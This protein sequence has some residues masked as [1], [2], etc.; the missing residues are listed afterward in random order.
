MQNRNKRAQVHVN[1][2]GVFCLCRLHFC[3]C[4]EVVGTDKRGGKEELFFGHL[5]KKLTHY[6]HRCGVLR[7]RFEPHLTGRAVFGANAGSFLY[8]HV[9]PN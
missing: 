5:S 4:V 9:L 1:E 6:H 8:F 3:C 2:S 7:S